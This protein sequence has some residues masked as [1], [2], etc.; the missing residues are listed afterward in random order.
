MNTAGVSRAWAAMW[1]ALACPAGSAADHLVE[2]GGGYGLAF[3][4]SH[5][6]IAPGDTVTFRNTGGFHN[7]RSDAAAF[8][9]ANG[10]DGEGGSGNAIDNAWTV[11]RR[12][13]RT[14]NFDV[15]C[16]PHG[17]PGLGMAAVVTVE[18]S[19]PLGSGYT[20]TWYDPAQSGQGIFIEVLPGNLLLAYWF[21]FS[22]EGQQAWFGGVGTIVGNTATISATRTTGARFIPEFRPADAIRA[23]WG[24]LRLSFS[25]CQ[26]GRVDYSS[27]AGFGS[28]S[29]SLKRLSQP[30]GLTCP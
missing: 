11:T 9:C 15:Y 17:A 3:D 18:G 10:C 19:A 8:R 29:M 27:I 7:V 14:G 16:E 6:F 1:L 4:P 5:V 30:S 2:L 28:G 13:D 23:D 24:E 26:N 22:P 25:D 21:T 20:G 12:F